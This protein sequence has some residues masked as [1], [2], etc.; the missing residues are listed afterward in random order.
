MLVRMLTSTLLALVCSASFAHEYT[1]GE[2]HIAH[3][4][5]RAL[6]PNA[7]TGAAYFVIHNHG[8]TEDR[9]IGAATPRAAK[10][11]LH[12]IVQLGEVMKMQ[13]LDSVGIPVGGEVKFAPGGTHLMLFGLKQPLVAGERFPLTLQFEKAGK[14][15]VEVAIE[16]EAPAA[17]EHANH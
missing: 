9:L 17:D 8:Q 10:A 13:H 2:L 3:P 5:A 7:P 1:A 14:V 16:A 6:P 15:D 11:E 12:T 4:W